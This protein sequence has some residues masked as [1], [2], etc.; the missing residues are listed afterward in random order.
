[1]K[2]I[3]AGLLGSHVFAYSNWR[4]LARAEGGVF[5]PSDVKSPFTGR[6]HRPSFRVVPTSPQPVFTGWS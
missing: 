5:Q 6:L 1:M 4:Y 2:L 3:R